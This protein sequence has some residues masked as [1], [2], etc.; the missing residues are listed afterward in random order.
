MPVI[1]SS[2]D[3]IVLQGYPTGSVFFERYSAHCARCLKDNPKDWS[4][5]SGMVTMPFFQLI[6]GLEAANQGWPRMAFS[7]PPLIT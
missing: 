5:E 1:S 2:N 7:F 6:A 3:K 4:F